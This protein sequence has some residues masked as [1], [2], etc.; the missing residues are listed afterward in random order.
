MKRGKIRLNLPSSPKVTKGGVGLLKTGGFM[1]NNPKVSPPG[2]GK[3]NGPGPSRMLAPTP[4]RP[5]SEEEPSLGRRSLDDVTFRHRNPAGPDL[6]PTIK[7]EEIELR[8]DLADSERLARR[9]IQAPTTHAVTENLEPQAG[10]I[11][12]R[13]N[14]PL[15]AQQAG[16]IASTN[17]DIESILTAA[18][19]RDAVL[20][21]SGNG[22]KAGTTVQEVISEPPAP[23]LPLSK[24]RTAPQPLQTAE[25]MVPSLPTEEVPIVKKTS[26]GRVRLNLSSTPTITQFSEEEERRP[27]IIQP[28]RSTLPTRSQVVQPGEVEEE[29]R[30][31]AVVQPTRSTLPTRSQVVQPDEEEETPAALNAILQRL[32]GDKY[33]PVGA[34][35]TVTPVPVTPPPAPTPKKA[36]HVQV[37]ATFRNRDRITLPTVEDEPSVSIGNTRTTSVTVRPQHALVAAQQ[38]TG[39]SAPPITSTRKPPLAPSRPKQAL[40]PKFQD[41]E[42]FLPTTFQS[43]RV[44]LLQKALRSEIGS[45]LDEALEEVGVLPARNPTQPAPAGHARTARATL[46]AFDGTPLPQPTSRVRDWLPL[47]A[48]AQPEFQ[49]SEPLEA[50]PERPERPMRRNPQVPPVTAQ[51]EITIDDDDEDDPIALLRRRSQQVKGRHAGSNVTDTPPPVTRV[52]LGAPRVTGGEKRGDYALSHQE[53][54]TPTPTTFKLSTQEKLQI[55][56]GE[57]YYHS[58]PDEDRKYY[59]DRVPTPL[60]QS[61][62]R[63]ALSAEGEEEV[64]QRNQ[65]VTLAAGRR[66]AL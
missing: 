61:V 31:S 66:R 45:I 59:H 10:P 54:A 1:F 17:V 50:A 34:G 13:N 62:S 7:Y 33:R 18:H 14:I 12:L 58:T 19:R 29:E 43:H 6:R 39:Y 38:D 2:R 23:S 35:T 40:I 48:T 25:V 27:A 65:R 57:Q 46:P 44:P 63:G 32:Q 5:D 42:S 51:P 53:P 22:G 16:T 60:R 47:T 9:D 55:G 20:F 28:T 21:G 64:E 4:L 41:E 49:V 3:P 30:R 36:P 37:P 24:V 26:G 52:Q 56:S 11:R 8:Y 15:P